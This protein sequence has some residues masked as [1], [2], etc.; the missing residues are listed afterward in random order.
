M[1]ATD[2]V[3]TNST[4][5]STVASSSTG[6]GSPWSPGASARR[7]LDQE[8]WE[9]GH[10]TASSCV[11]G[12]IAV[13]ARCVPDGTFL[14]GG[15]STLLA[16]ISLTPWPPLPRGGGGT[17]SAGVSTSLFDDLELLSRSM[18][19]YPCSMAVG[20]AAVSARGP[21]IARDA[22][23]GHGGAVGGLLP[24]VRA[25]WRHGPRRRCSFS[26]TRSSLAKQFFFNVGI[27]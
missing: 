3:T 24:H 22:D 19:S 23:Y 2:T 18:I 10:V 6:P 14:R 16:F 1:A 13:D 15:N 17:L 11:A 27:W 20:G 9:R 4:L 25:Q 5:Y 26:I 12:A 7:S 21:L 8:S